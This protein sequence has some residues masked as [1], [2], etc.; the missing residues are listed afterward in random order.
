[1]RDYV[2][3]VYGFNLMYAETLVK[4]LSADQMVEQPNGVINHPAWSLGHLVVSADHLG[5]MLGLE[6][7]LPE[8]WDKTLHLPRVGYRRPTWQRIR[9]KTRFS[10]RSRN[11]T[12]ATRK[13][14]RTP[15][16]SRGLSPIRMRR[17]GRTSRRLAT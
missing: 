8:G 1:M 16:L 9:R 15:S 14:C 11:S 3:F 13:R 6:S 2:A 10:V 17:R 4:G 5:S 7:S 12:R